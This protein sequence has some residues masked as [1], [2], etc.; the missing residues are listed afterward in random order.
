MDNNI[1]NANMDVVN[2]RDLLIRY[3]KK[4]YWFLLAIIIAFILAFFYLKSTDVKYNIQTTIMLR[5]D[6]NT[7]GGDQMA[8]LESLG[9]FNASKSLE[10]E[11]QVINSHKIIGQAIDSLEL[12]TEY[13]EKDGLK[14]V[15]KYANLPIKLVIPPYY[16]DTLKRKIQIYLKEKGGSYIVKFKYGNFRQ[17]YK[18]SNIQEP[19][20][21]P[22]GELKFQVIKASKEYKKYKILVYPMKNLVASYSSKI[23]A[24]AVNKLST[25][26]I[27]ISMVESNVK[28]AEDFLNKLVELYNLDAI[29]D[30]NLIATNTARFLTDRLALI[31]QELFTVESDVEKYKKSNSITD[32]SS[33]ASIYLQSSSEYGK[34]IADLET[35]LKLIQ[36]IDGYIK[37]DKNQYS[38]IPAN[39]GIEDQGLV[40]LIQTYNTAILDRM[41]LVKTSNENNPA[42]IDLE[43]QIKALRSNII[44]S[45]NN[46]KSGLVIS[47]NDVTRREMEFNSRI[48][49]VPTQERQFLEIKRQQEIKQNLYLFLSQ[50]REENALALAS[51]AP[52]ARTID[53]A[54]ASLAPVSPKKMM[55]YLVALILGLLVPFL[56]IYLRDLINNKIEDAKEFQKIVKAPYLGNICI[57]RE[58]E[59][60]VVEEGKVTPIVEMFRLIRT[61]LQF[62]TASKKSPAILVTSTISGEGKSFISINLAMSFALMKKKVILVGM[63]IR[64]PMLG[65]YMHIPKKNGLTVYLSDDSYQVNDIIMPSG[66]HNYLDVIPAGPVPPNPSELLMSSRLD[67]LMEELR[68]EYDYIIVDSAPIGMVSDTYLLSRVVDNSVFV[69]RQDYTP[70]DSCQLINDIYEEKR[71]ND[72]GVVL[73]GTP[74]TSSYGYGY[75]YGYGSD[76]RRKQSQKAAPKITFGDK[77]NDLFYKI[78]KK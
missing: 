4:W 76:Y 34:K 21:T 61:N 30:K 16:T 14:Y 15:E 20:K 73:N 59:R 78:F 17:T 31:T 60:V 72:M 55:I 28:K 62:M 54:Y 47:K 43:E 3:L 68:K 19:F 66:F 38:L 6:D 23:Q 74:A 75:G 32:I 36:Y 29:S 50:K 65:E 9:L 1:G 69:A 27:K 48:R 24:G 51:T 35:Q 44:S 2:L 70:N 37:N 58:A 41:R 67:E 26:T 63:D 49:A 22:A 11:I 53:K 33:E 18:L 25:N 39:I 52:A 10:D 13:Y 5:N 57:S 71:L 77:V 42:L 64:N 46:V 8:M 45:V 40:S 12:Q 56:I 7:S